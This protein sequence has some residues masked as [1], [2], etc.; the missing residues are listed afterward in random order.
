ML[1]VFFCFC[2]YSCENKYCLKG[3][4]NIKE[5]SVKYECL[6]SDQAA[7]LVLT[8]FMDSNCD[9]IVTARRRY[10]GKRSKSIHQNFLLRFAV[11][12]MESWLLADRK[13]IAS[14]L[15]VH[16]KKIP[17]DPDM[18]VDPKKRLAD[19]AHLSRKKIIKED[20]F[21]KNGRP[22]QRYLEIMEKFVN[23]DWDIEGA[24]KHSQSLWR[25]VTRLRGLIVT[26]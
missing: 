23:N 7:V 1:V 25:C 14:L 15:G 2:E 12:E 24:M 17:L 8:D 9:C 4:G 20:L 26:S 10:L 13:N 19:L 6:A 21:A 5:K 18:E 3:S 16:E 11:N 22:G